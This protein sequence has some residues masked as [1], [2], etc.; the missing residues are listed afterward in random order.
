VKTPRRRAGTRPPPISLG[1]IEGGCCRQ[2]VRAIVRKGMVTDLAVEPCP[3]TMSR[4]AGPELV[5]LLKV[6][7]RRARAAAGGRRPTPADTC[8]SFPWQP[9]AQR[10]RAVLFRDMLVRMVHCLLYADRYRCWLD[11]REAH[12]R[13]DD[14]TLPGPGVAAPQRWLAVPRQVRAAAITG[15]AR[16]SRRRA[17]PALAR[18]LFGREASRRT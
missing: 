15:R 11:L 10:Q 18:P 1:Y 4:K 13:Y 5:R 6:A 8:G 3:E 7:Q 9:G 12:H 14:R 17:G 16:G 2:L